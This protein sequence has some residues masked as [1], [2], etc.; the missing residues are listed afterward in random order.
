MKTFTC[1]KCDDSYTEAIPTNDVHSYNSVVTAPTCTTAGYTTYTCSRCEDTYTENG[2]AATDHSYANGTCTACGAADPDYEEPATGTYEKATSIEVGDKVIFVCESK[3]MEMASISATSTKYGIGTAYDNSPAATYV[4]TVEAGYTSGTYAFKDSNN[5]YLYWSSG[6]SLNTTT[7]KNNNS[8]WSVTFSNGNAVIKNKGDATRQIYWNASSPRFACYTSSQTA[9]Q[10]YK[11]TGGNGGGGNGGGGAVKD[12]VQLAVFEFTGTKD[13]T[14]AQSSYSETSG[15]Y[16]LNLTGSNLFV[17]SKS[18]ND[19]CLKLGSS[20]KNGSF[21]FVV[22]THVTKV[23][24]Y[25]AK[26]GS[27]TSTITVAGKTYSLTSEYT[28]IEIN[29]TPGAT[30]SVSA[31]KR[32]LI[33][34]LEFWGNES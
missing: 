9:I 31:T 5:N 7:S 13:N 18:N 22:P 33:N 1:S 14:T 26:F 8:S 27:D 30:I 3:K 23:V 21:E 15:T 28:K 4:F 32:V 2:E 12:P 17:P 29:T 24:I 19:W 10:L 11:L 20:S 16:T 25:A 34:T 6:N